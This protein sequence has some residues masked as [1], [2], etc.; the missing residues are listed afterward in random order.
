MGC[1]DDKEDTGPYQQKEER[2]IFCPLLVG[3]GGEQEQT[4]Q[5]CTD[6]FPEWGLPR[7]QEHHRHRN[8]EIDEKKHDSCP[9]L[10]TIEYC[11]TGR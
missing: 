11:F 10:P 1:G 8:E 7:V 6:I 2:R 4:M 3:A 5:V 9:R